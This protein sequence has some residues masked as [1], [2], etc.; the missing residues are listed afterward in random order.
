MIYGEGRLMGLYILGGGRERN[1]PT[2]LNI[3]IGYI[4]SL[5]ISRDKNKKVKIGLLIKSR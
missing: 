5:Q 3:S 4:T 2:E 1:V